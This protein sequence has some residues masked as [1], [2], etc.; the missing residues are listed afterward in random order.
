ML[1]KEK[2]LDTCQSDYGQDRSPPGHLES[3][4]GR[5][6][7]TLDSQSGIPGYLETLSG[8]GFSTPIRREFSTPVSQIGFL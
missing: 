5:G 4:P 1:R 3:I 7:A 6:F 8:R 2:I